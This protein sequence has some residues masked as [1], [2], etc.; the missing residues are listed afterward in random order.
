VPTKLELLE[1][2]LERGFPLGEDIPPVLADPERIE[3]LRGAV[4][5]IAAED[6]VVEMVGD[7]GF[8]LERPGVEGFLESW[9]DWIQPFETFRVELEDVIES[10]PHLVVLVRQTGRPRGGGTEIENE[11]AAV[12]TFRGQRLRRVE[13]HLD[14]GMALRAA[15]L[16][17]QS[18]Q[19]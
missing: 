11:G 5:E 7:E 6:L 9:R 2:T 4:D 10:G 19:E 12:W 18:G 13:F 8:R 16:D 17:P 3:R 1:R 14:R 15:G